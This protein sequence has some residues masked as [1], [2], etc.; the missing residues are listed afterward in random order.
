[1][2]DIRVTLCWDSVQIHFGDV[3]HL[4]LQ[5]KPLIVQAWVDT[6]LQKR[7]QIEYTM[8]GGVTVLTQYDDVEKFRAILA[9]LEKVLP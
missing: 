7:W 2:T 3:L 1:V 5:E 9:G 6:P 8:P 4:H